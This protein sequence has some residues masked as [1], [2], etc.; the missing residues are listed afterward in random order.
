ML[1]KLSMTTFRYNPRMQKVILAFGTHDPEAPRHWNN[2]KQLKADG[3]TVLEC[4]SPARGLLRNL[5]WLWQEGRKIIPRVDAVMVTFPGHYFFPLAWVLTRRPRKHLIFDAFI[6]LH[7]T[8]VHDRKKISVWHPYA[9]FLYVLDWIDCHLADEI[10]IDTEVHRQF[11]IQKFGLNPA[12]IKTIYLGTRDD[13]FIPKKR[14][15]ESA[16]QRSVLFYGTFIPLQGVGYII[17]AAKILQSE[18]PDIHFTLVGSG[19]TH[20]DMKR[21]TEA[22]G[23][24]NVTFSPRARFEDVPALIHAADLCLGVFGTSGKAARV[25]PHKVYDAVACGVPIV[26]G[27]SPAV[28]EKFSEADGVYFAERGSGSS[29]AAAIQKLL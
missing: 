18:R 1:R 9:W 19:Q 25:I 27:D 29:L 24:R 16:S 2:V 14:V 20:G 10:W 21:K 6:S 11:F 26:T 28:R 15:S 17:D 3:W 13:L 22:Y 7:D 23:L 8:L 12:R 5:R 4:R